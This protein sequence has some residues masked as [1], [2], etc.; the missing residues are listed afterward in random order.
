MSTKQNNHL[1]PQITEDKKDQDMAFSLKSLKIK[2]TRTW[3]SGS[4]H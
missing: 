2:K 4:N 3:H 1:S